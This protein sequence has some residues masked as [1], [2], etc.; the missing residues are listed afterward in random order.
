LT[1]A[2]CLL[3][4]SSCWVNFRAVPVGGSPSAPVDPDAAVGAF[5][6]Q[7]PHEPVQRPQQEPQAVALE[8]GRRE[9]VPPRG[10]P[11]RERR[12]CHCHGEPRH[13]RERWML[14]WTGAR[15]S[16]S[17]VEL[18]AV[19]TEPDQ[20]RRVVVGE[21]GLQHA[22]RVPLA[23]VR[24]EPR[25]PA[26]R[27]DS[28]LHALRRDGLS[29]R[30]LP[31][32]GRPGSHSMPVIALT[33]SVQITRWARAWP[34]PAKV[35]TA[36][37]AVCVTRLT[38]APSRIWPATSA[39]IACCPSAISAMNSSSV[40][41]RGAARPEPVRYLGHGAG[42][43]LASVPGHLGPRVRLHPVHPGGA[44]LQVIAQPAVGPGAP[45]TRSRA[46]STSTSSPARPSSRAATSPA[47]PAPMTTT[48]APTRASSPVRLSCGSDN[49]GIRGH[50]EGNPKARGRTPAPARSPPAPG[51]R[52]PVK[53]GKTGR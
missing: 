35:T 21:L 16:A 38:V 50:G 13:A 1:A 34:P 14:P 37:S 41:A 24:D 6:V 40:P 25:Y 49:R 15:S 10:A 53:S 45:P 8:S 46:S 9:Q 12:S 22:D 26:A 47:N 39:A 48:S 36:P 33:G 2:R 43:D 42:R 19:G 18:G 23:R 5:L 29:V 17:H 30:P 11:S 4:C 52:A 44:E 28:D 3:S 7:L 27:L 20:D 51:P 31:G 32:T